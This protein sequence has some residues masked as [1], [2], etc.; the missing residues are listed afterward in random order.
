MK[1]D[2]EQQ[3]NDDDDRVYSPKERRIESKNGRLLPVLLV[4]LLVVAIAGGIYY[5]ITKPRADGGVMLQSK[6]VAFEEKIAS[7][8]RQI[9]D[10]QGKVGAG[11]G[12]DPALLQRLDALA[13]KVE[14]LEK[15]AHSTAE[16]KSKPAPPK[17]AVKVQNRYHT[18]QKGETLFKIS[19][20]YGITVEELRRLNGLSGGQS[21]RTGQKLLISMEK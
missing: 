11:G 17:P 15:R 18:V 5:F 21:V 4:I 13:Q 8:E 2:S 6:M 19:K 9:A 12:P 14:V 16:S 1:D 10:L 20:K 7:L 3:M